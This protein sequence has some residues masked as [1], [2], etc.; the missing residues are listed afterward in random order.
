MLASTMA[1]C[2]ALACQPHMAMAH[3]PTEPMALPSALIPKDAKRELGVKGEPCSV[4]REGKLVK[5]W[6]GKSSSG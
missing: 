1:I 2:S 3:I 4:V 6:A 5:G